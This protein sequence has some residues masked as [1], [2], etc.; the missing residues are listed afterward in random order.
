[1][2]KIKSGILRKSSLP[3]G[4][5]LLRFIFDLCGGKYLESD[6]VP[7][8]QSSARAQRQKIVFCFLISFSGSLVDAIEKIIR[9]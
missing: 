1:M 8:A 2:L 3:A 7:A 9:E 5:P 6:H 4:H